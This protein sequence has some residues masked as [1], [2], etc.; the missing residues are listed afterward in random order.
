[1]GFGSV[2]I[3]LAAFYLVRPAEAGRP[4]WLAWLA[5]AATGCRRR[6]GVVAR[7]DGADL[8]AAHADHARSGGAGAAQFGLAMADSGAELICGS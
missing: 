2:G 5:V 7:G 3:L 8:V 6:N 4:R 1:M